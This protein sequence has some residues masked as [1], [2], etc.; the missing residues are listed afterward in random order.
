[1][2]DARWALDEVRRHHGDVPVVLLGYSMGGPDRSSVDGDP[3]V[4]GLVLL[5]PGLLPSEPLRVPL[6]VPV[7]ILHGD[8]DRITSPE[9]SAAWESGCAERALTCPFS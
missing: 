2:T 4:R 1:M 9:A 6:G 3:L 8:Q 5:A 7:C